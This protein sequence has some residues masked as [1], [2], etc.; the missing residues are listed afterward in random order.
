MTTHI[1]KNLKTFRQG[2]NWSQRDISSLLN[3]SI[4]AYSKIE[5]GITDPN[6]SRLYQIATI[7][8]VTI[9]DLISMDGENPHMITDAE[10]KRCKDKSLAAEG[11]IVILQQK[12]ISLHE[13]LRHLT[14]QVYQL[15]G[16]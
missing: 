6:I 16:I 4:P 5:T 15:K 11:Q 7:L 2:K 10:L 12:I 3:I 9:I 13:E 8:D 1:C 14:K